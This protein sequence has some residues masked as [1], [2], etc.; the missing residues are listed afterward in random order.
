MSNICIVKGIDCS[1]SIRCYDNIIDKNPLDLLKFKDFMFLVAEGSNILINKTMFK[2]SIFV[3][4]ELYD[5]PNLI[6][7]AITKEDTKNL[8]PNPSDEEKTRVYELIGILR[9]GSATRIETGTFY[10]EDSL[11]SK[12]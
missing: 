5:I 6:Q 7:I 9:D 2:N 8:F 4:K 10:L 1:I 12:L 11:I 3:S